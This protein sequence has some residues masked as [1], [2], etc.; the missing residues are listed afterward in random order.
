MLIKT[1]SKQERKLD[2]RYIGFFKEIWGERKIIFD[3]AKNDFKSKYTNSLLGVIWAFM[4]PLTVILVLWFVFQI[5]FRSTP[6]D[7]IPFILWYIPAFLAWNF[8]SDALGAGSGCIFDY[9]YLVKNMQFR[10]STLPMVKIISSSFVHFFFIGFIFLIY[11]I[12]GWYPNIYNLQVLYYYFCMIVLLLGLTWIMSALSVFSRDILNIISLIVQVGFWA[13]PLIWDPSTMPENIQKIVKINPMY[14]ICMGYREA[15]SSHVWFW[16][17]PVLT[18]Y[19]WIFTLMF[20]FTGSYVFHKL[21][22]Q[23]ADML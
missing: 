13:T 9:S 14:Y 7:N 18:V 2:M 4:L 1:K 19:F 17:H 6:V 23:F 3:L 16:E 11:F 15:F 20:L 21:R 8:F 10:V 12:Y 5:G 22:P